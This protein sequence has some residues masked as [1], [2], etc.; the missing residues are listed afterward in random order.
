MKHGPQGCRAKA[1]F[2][3]YG[4]DAS[5]LASTNAYVRIDFAVADFDVSLLNGRCYAELRHFSQDGVKQL[6]F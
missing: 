4:I 1:L 3:L 2:D 6:G 5:L